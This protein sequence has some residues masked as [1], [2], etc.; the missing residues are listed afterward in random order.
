MTLTA[1]DTID[2]LDPPPRRRATGWIV[3]RLVLAGVYVLAVLAVG[4]LHRTD[5]ELSDLYHDVARGEVAAVTLVPGTGLG[6]V[7]GAV[8]QTAQWRTGLHRWTAELPLL[9]DASVVPGAIGSPANPQ[10]A[11]LPAGGSAQPL[12]ALAALPLPSAGPAEPRSAGP[13]PTTRYVDGTSPILARTR[14]D[15]IA[16][17][18]AMK[19][20]LRITQRA[21]PSEVDLFGLRLPRP[22]A[23]PLGLAFL[24]GLV[25]L[26]AGRQPWRAT[27][28][29]WL[30]FAFLP[31]GP[32]AFL[33]L[34]GPTPGLPSA[35]DQRRLTGGKAFLLTVTLGWLVTVGVSQLAPVV[36]PPHA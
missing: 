3:L 10:A 7:T 14:A 35:N 26:I 28:W 21:S 32:L 33:L 9:A 5:A 22:A 23:L 12:P 29:A 8:P 30:W 17:L 34:S 1:P 20:D 6:D 15:V 19:P 11:P 2:Y 31:G 24:L 27:R 13:Y 16:R 18:R 4:V 36:W 25:V